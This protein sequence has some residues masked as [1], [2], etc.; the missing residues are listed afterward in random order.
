MILSFFHEKSTAFE[1]NVTIF[2]HESNRSVR[3]TIERIVYRV[4]C[5]TRMQREFYVHERD[6]LIFQLE[7]TQIKH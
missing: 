7:Q 3:R 1:S 5:E 2:R 4:P 6:T